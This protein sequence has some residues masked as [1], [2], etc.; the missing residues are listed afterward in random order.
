M[1]TV[2]IETPL[3]GQRDIRD[4]SGVANVWGGLAE[5]TC[6]WNVVGFP[7]ISVPLPVGDGEMPVGLQIIGRPHEDEKLLSVASAVAVVLTEGES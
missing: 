2:G 5:Q 1:P 7:A 6:P 3:I 4:D